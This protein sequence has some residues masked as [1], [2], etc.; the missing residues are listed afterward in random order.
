MQQ[1]EGF[2]FGILHDIQGKLHIT[3]RCAADDIAHNAGIIAGSR[4][5][6][7]NGIGVGFIKKIVD[8]K[9]FLTAINIRDG[10]LCANLLVCFCIIVQ[11][12]IISFHEGTYGGEG[13]FTV[14]S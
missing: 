4:Q 5:I 12:C 14:A 8:N 13:A 1:A 9:G 10:K 7:V 11:H 6:A 2:T 3:K